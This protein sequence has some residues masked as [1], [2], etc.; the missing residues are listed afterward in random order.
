MPNTEKEAISP[1]EKHV[2]CKAIKQLC[3]FASNF[4]HIEALVRIKLVAHTFTEWTPYRHYQKGDKKVASISK[5]NEGPISPPFPMWQ[6]VT[7]YEAGIA[8]KGIRASEPLV[9]GDGALT[10]TPLLHLGVHLLWPFFFLSKFG[11]R[12]AYRKTQHCYK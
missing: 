3:L 11:M 6:M 9:Y 8:A 4:E 12:I 10:F 5:K 2:S 1:F 7:L